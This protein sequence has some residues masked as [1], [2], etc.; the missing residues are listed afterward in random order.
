MVNNNSILEMKNR[1]IYHLN[2]VDKK[3]QKFRLI[4]ST[5]KFDNSIQD[6]RSFLSAEE[7]NILNKFK[8]IS[9]QNEFIVGRVLTKE[10]ILQITNKFKPKEISILSG[11]WGFPILDCEGLDK[12]WVSIAHSKNYGASLL[13]EVSTHPIGVD[14]EE[15]KTSNNESLSY[16]LSSYQKKITLEEKHI[17]WASIE[18]VS[19][20]LRTGFTVSENLFEISKIENHNSY[21]TIIFKHLP[22]LRAHT[23]IENKTV[24]SVGYPSELKF[25]FIRKL[26]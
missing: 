11:V 2:F 22:K 19:K 25:D 20:A 15:I 24:I 23:W 18:A 9:R 26:N 6:F 10:N 12:M 7:L 16:F 3:E 1:K 5:V 8:V 14:I 21:Y 4:L 17:Y 13:S